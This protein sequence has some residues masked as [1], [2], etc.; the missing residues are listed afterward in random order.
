MN[1]QYYTCGWEGYPHCYVELTS[2]QANGFDD[3]AIVEVIL[4]IDGN[5][6]QDDLGIVVVE[7]TVGRL[8]D[9]ARE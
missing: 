9:I 3:E 2:A 5:R 8:Q 6:Q 1:T 7:T 4:D